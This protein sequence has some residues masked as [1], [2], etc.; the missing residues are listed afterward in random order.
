MPLIKNGSNRLT[1]PVIW[2]GDFFM[3]QKE[4]AEKIGVRLT[5][6]GSRISAGSKLKGK[7]IR[8][9]TMKEALKYARK[10]DTIAYRL[11]E[12]ETVD[13]I[14]ANQRWVR[15]WVGKNG[16]EAGGAARGRTPATEDDVRAADPAA[17]KAYKRA[18]KAEPDT[19]FRG[20]Q[21]PDGSVSVY[22]ASGAI[23]TRPSRGEIP[24]EI[25]GACSWL[26]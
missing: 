22:L 14:G 19:K 2:G 5:D 13:I 7:E 21:W 9:A 6:P 16:I 20:V 10:T 1:K 24:Q 26:S 11:R 15:A 3:S 12:D 23:L 18:K 4:L 17:V 25:I 8:L